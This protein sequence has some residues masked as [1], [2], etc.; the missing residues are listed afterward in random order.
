MFPNMKKKKIRAINQEIDNPSIFYKQFK[1]SMGMNNNKSYRIPGINYN[2]HRKKG[3]H[4]ISDLL[5]YTSKYGSDGVKAFFAHTTGDMFS[6]FLVE[7]Y[8]SFTRNVIEDGLIE[9][10]R[11]KYRKTRNF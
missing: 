9:F 7:H 3:G 11:K 6:D 1:K 4:D 5:Y 2:N 10:S 8:G